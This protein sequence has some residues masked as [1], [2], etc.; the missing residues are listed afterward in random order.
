MAEQANV[1]GIRRRVGDT[2][3][4]LVTGLGVLGRDKTIQTQYI[5]Q[6]LTDD[7]LTAAYRGD[8]MARK[9]V[10][11][12]ADDATRAWREW[13]TDQDKITAIETEE[14][15]L[16]LQLKLKQALIQSRLYGGSAIFMGVR[17]DLPETPLDTGTVKQGD[18][19]FVHP[20][21][22]M[23]VSVGDR[24]INNVLDPLYGQ[25]TFYQLTGSD[26]GTVRVHPTRVVKLV[27]SPL[28]DHRISGSDSI[29]GDSVLQSVDDAIKQAGSTL[30]SI[31]TMA[32]ESTVDVI[33]VPSLIDSVTDPGYESQLIERFA[34]AMN[35]KSTVNA[36]LLDKEEEWQRITQSFVG[37][38][39]I[40]RLFLLVV[41]GAADIPAT[42]LLGQSPA[43][44][45]STGESDIRNYYDKISSEQETT[46]RPALAR[47][48]EVIVR[49]ALGD[50]PE[51][52]HYY[53]SPLWQLSDKEKAEVAKSKADA[54]RIDV[55]AG[56]LPMDALRK[57]RANQLIEDGTY[58][59][60][61]EAIAESEDPDLDE[62]D[63][64]VAEQFAATGATAEVQKQ[65]LNG[66][67]I[68]A[69]QEIIAAVVA[70]DMP[71]ET[72]EKLIAV[73]FPFLSAG[74][75]TAM[76]QPLDNFEK[77]PAPAPATV[78]SGPPRLTVVPGG[79]EPLQDGVTQF[80]VGN[81]K[82]NIHLEGEGGFT[83]DQVH[84]LVGQ[85]TQMMEDARPRT[86]YVHRKVL[87]AGDIL[88][89]AAGQGIKNLE[90]AGEL[91][92]TVVHSRAPVDWMKIGT[93]YSEKLVVPEG[94]PRIIEL[95]PARDGR[96]AL[97]LQFSSSELEGRHK[98]M[99]EYG[100]SHDFDDYQPHIT[101][102][103]DPGDIDL[104]KIETYQGEI[105]LGPEVF[106]EVREQHISTQ[107]DDRPL[108]V[109]V[110]VD[111]RQSGNKT[112]RVTRDPI[113]G[114]MVIKME[115]REDG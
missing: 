12:P 86:L 105:K 91:H 108:V 22:K 83:R 47:L 41:S 71:R 23:S 7:Q 61:A 70:G 96:K 114:E 21:S 11:I 16:L 66:A 102:A 1:V 37:L 69:A 24:V 113:T 101:L 54:H 97:V 74:D 3:R 34:L 84:E 43:G 75:I 10:D 60:L 25:P 81:R 17:D 19:K 95:W 109:N 110:Q 20:V 67:Q 88:R 107:R 6:T 79:R 104:E 63:P 98:Q 48:D 82:I 62:G 111:A 106:D 87:N 9:I 53:W 15:R 32:S 59:G 44:L 80:Q 112:G 55:D 35:A 29:W 36:L 14:R 90:S 5:F 78:P 45:N 28:P 49:S 52:V 64:V 58:P 89:W 77:A 103:Y 51:D 39:D 26:V 13:Q 65:A 76:M 2:L 93:T 42:R 50:F 8:W 115:E 73:S 27:G 57:G 46:L 40:V 38:P 30:G 72:A 33:K 31:S 18:L 100:C 85:L 56:L 99:I 92:V 94:G 68:A 4:N